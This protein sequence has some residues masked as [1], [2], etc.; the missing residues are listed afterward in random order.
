VAAGLALL[1]G[2]ATLAASKAP[3]PTSIVAAYSL[4]MSASNQPPR[5]MNQKIWMKGKK[6]R[7]ELTMPQGKQLTVGNS[8]GVYMTMPGMKAA[9]KLP[10]EI[11]AKGSPSQMLMGD[12]AKIRSGKKVGAEKVGRYQ[13]E[14]YE[15]KA[16]SRMPGAEPGATSTTRIWVSKDLPIPVKVITRMPPHF[17][18]VQTLQSITLNG[19]IAESMFQLP[20]GTPI[21]QP[22]AP[23]KGGAGNAP[24][25]G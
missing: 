4:K 7:V 12:M 19:P 13:T 14:I 11:A 6:F 5:S 21:H 22:P 15:T 23:P 3:A 8:S 25:G 2:S 9:M 10:S 18:S 20:K 1:V 16:P 17:E 24:G